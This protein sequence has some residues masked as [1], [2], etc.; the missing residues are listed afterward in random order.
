MILPYCREKPSKEIAV[1]ALLINI[2]ITLRNEELSDVG[3]E[4]DSFSFAITCMWILLWT[5]QSVFTSRHVKQSI[6]RKDVVF[7]LGIK[8]AMSKQWAL[9][10]RWPTSLGLC[11]REHCLQ[12][13]GHNPSCL[14]NTAEMN[15]E[16]WFKS[17]APQYMRNMDIVEIA[18]S[19]TKTIMGLDT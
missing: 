11:Y 15:L 9:C 7:L 12:I 2:S 16:C 19:T 6:S 1:V 3:V 14:L 17:Q 18:Q 5:G 8:L 13:K 4:N 10:H